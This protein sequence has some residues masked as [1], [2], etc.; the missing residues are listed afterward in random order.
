MNN[1]AEGLAK[2]KKYTELKEILDDSNKAD[3]FISTKF[4]HICDRE[5]IRRV[6]LDYAYGKPLILNN[7]LES[8]T[9][10]A[11]DMVGS[12]RMQEIVYE[13][14]GDRDAIPRVVKEIKN[15]YKERFLEIGQKHKIIQRPSIRGDGGFFIYKGKDA[16]EL[17]IRAALETGREIQAANRNYS[18]LKRIL[19]DKFFKDSSRS[20]FSEVE[21]EQ[22]KLQLRVGIKLDD[23]TQTVSGLEDC[24]ENLLED[25]TVFYYVEDEVLGNSP[26][27]ASRLETA[28][29]ELT[30]TNPEFR[31]YPALIITTPENIEN[32]N[33][34]IGRE[35][36]SISEPT[37][38]FIRDK[39]WKG[40]I[41]VVQ[42]YKTHIPMFSIADIKKESEITELEQSL[43]TDLSILQSAC[44]FWNNEAKKFGIGELINEEKG[45]EFWLL[46]EIFSFEKGQ[47]ELEGLVKKGAIEIINNKLETRIFVKPEYYKKALS[48]IE[49]DAQKKHEWAVEIYERV[50]E[51][52]K[53]EK[54]KPENFLKYKLIA[55]QSF[56]T[57]Y[58]NP[59]R[60]A[61][62]IRQA[63]NEYDL[64]TRR[65][66]NF[67][68]PIYANKATE[69]TLELFGNYQKVIISNLDFSIRKASPLLSLLDI[70]LENIRKGAEDIYKK[71]EFLIK[72]TIEENNLLNRNLEILLEQRRVWERFRKIQNK[73]SKLNNEKKE[74]EE[75]QREKLVSE[76]E[77]IISSYSSLLKKVEELE[78]TSY[79][80]EFYIHK[81]NI[82]KDIAYFYNCIGNIILSKEK[83]D[84]EKLRE[85]YY[86]C[87]EYHLKSIEC[88]LEDWR[89]NGK[90]R[91][92]INSF[93]TA[94]IETS[95]IIGWTA[96]LE[97]KNKV[98]LRDKPPYYSELSEKTKKIFDMGF[99]EKIRYARR[100]ACRSASLQRK[101]YT[102]P[103]ELA[104][105][106]FIISDY[107]ID[108][109]DIK[110]ARRYFHLGEKNLRFA[111]ETLSEILEWGS[112]KSEL[113]PINRIYDFVKERLNESDKI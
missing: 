16:Y 91:R 13:K 49:K 70:N 26:N 93:N 80:S 50:L 57:L 48:N 109:K 63:A 20:C 96:E 112:K 83:Q 42:G 36:F 40:E 32:L 19:K 89:R 94:C 103:I 24:L 107:S 21:L 52:Y 37:E 66:D 104:E 31:N 10:V 41:V 88:C 69:L 59:H 71:T 72:K 8:V 97:R 39:G 30:N 62:L 29:K 11:M 98:S 33:K 79:Q 15:F 87:I 65:I 56:H 47:K 113:E 77:K 82:L 95:Y 3:E 110:R 1:K 22:L 53:E 9:S 12:V 58:Y 86:R 85:V 60:A 99:E 46:D 2:L 44:E 5:W 43:L 23:A 106:Y 84:H 90:K 76:L 73:N 68:S 100:I 7:K 6:L 105:T 102:G 111:E 38:V 51:K 25:N 28:G 4:P 108:L 61:D 55:R 74:F 78:G 14:T 35:I 81:R 64:L 18:L 101:A 45:I 92:S 27:L 75:E 34:E 54:I 67:L 17:A